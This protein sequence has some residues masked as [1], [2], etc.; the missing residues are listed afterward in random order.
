MAPETVEV[1]LYNPDNFVASVPHD[2]FDWLRA[3]D[4]VHFH[5]EPDG[6]GFWVLTRFDD[7]MHAS[8]E[9]SDFSSAHGT[10]IEDAQ[11]G[12]ELMMLNMDPPQHTKLRKLV[13]SGFTPRMIARTEP[14]IREIAAEIVDAVA[15]RGECDF[16]TEVA[17]ELPLQVIAEFIGIPLEDRHKIFTWSNT[18]IGLDDPEYANSSIEKATEAAAEMFG[19]ADTLATERRKTPRQDL[20]TKLI[21]AEVDDDQLT[22]MEFDAFFLLLAVAGNETTRNL[23]SGGMLA[24]MENPDERRKLI[25]D[26]SKIPT[27]IEEM[28]RMVTPVMHFRRTA[29]KDVEI[30]G[31]QIKEGDKVVVWYISANRD[32]DMFPNPHAFEGARNPNEHIAFGGGGP[33][34]CLGANLARLEIRVMFEEILKRLPDMELTDTPARLR[35]NFINGLKHMPVRFTPER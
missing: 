2:I 15:K 21:Q 20:V 25:E 11:G 19:Y 17:A 22:D 23:I 32:A 35:S 26:Q 34:F 24:L 10:S 13:S 9:W 27:A 28:L 6:P 18:M 8:R 1:D 3:N 4:P 5:E 12:A 7:V 30:R 14:H 29:T 33:H 31:H 16:V